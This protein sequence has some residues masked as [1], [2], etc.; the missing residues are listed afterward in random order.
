[1]TPLTLLTRAATSLCALLLLALQLQPHTH[2]L[3]HAWGVDGHRFVAEIAQA[4]LNK[5]ASMHVSEILG[6]QLDMAA[7][8][9][10]AD[11]AKHNMP[12]YAHTGA[13][14]YMNMHHTHT[15]NKAKDMCPGLDFHR[16]CYSEEHGPGVCL[17]IAIRNMTE[18][19][20]SL[21]PSDYTDL[22]TTN[23]LGG[24][25]VTLKYL[26]HLT[27]DASQPLHWGFSNDRGGNRIR[28]KFFGDDKVDVSFSPDPYQVNLHAMWDSLMIERRLEKRFNFSH[29][30][31]L[32][33]L[34]AMQKTMPSVYKMSDPNNNMGRAKEWGHLGAR[35]VCDQV[36]MVADGHRMVSEAPA[37]GKRDAPWTDFD[38]G[39]MYYLRAMPIVEQQ[40]IFGGM[41]L[42]GLL[43]HMWPETRRCLGTLPEPATAGVRVMGILAGVIGGLGLCAVVAITVRNH[44]MGLYAE[45]LRKHRTRAAKAKAK[46]AV[47][48]D[49][50]NQGLV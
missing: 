40:L 48:L 17:P 50:G 20:L 16:G 45:E 39:E 49:G 35:L 13:W 21:K 3:T 9:T 37:V 19:M 4:N 11:Y 8:A 30:R 2:T 28:G 12:E 44:R 5:C 15:G 25:N 29:P 32:E 34:L 33:N 36:L 31:M 10:W 26:I 42:A 46:H 27:G 6:G 47:N 24:A 43:N 38:L 22:E 7:V 18:T 23:Q 41:R 1:M 14:H